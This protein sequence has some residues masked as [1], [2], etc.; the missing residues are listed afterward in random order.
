MLGHWQ[1]PNIDVLLTIFEK[2]EKPDLLKC[3]YTCAAWNTAGNILLYRKVQPSSLNKFQKLIQTISE[4]SPSERNTA[5]A[6]QQLRHLTKD[7]TLTLQC[8]M[9]N[10]S[11]HPMAML[12]RI[13]IEQQKSESDTVWKM[14]RRQ[15]LG[16]LIKNVTLKSLAYNDVAGYLTQLM[17]FV[18]SSPNVQTADIDYLQIYFAL[19]FTP[20]LDWEQHIGSNWRQLKDLTLRTYECYKCPI[21]PLSSMESMLQHLYR[22]DTLDWPDFLYHLPHPVPNMKNLQ[23]LRVDISNK[24]SYEKLKELLQSCR[25]TLR[26]LSIR[27]C[28]TT[29]TDHA[30]LDLEGLIKGLVKLKDFA[31]TYGYEHIFTISSFGD[32]LETLTLI[33]SSVEGEGQVH[34][35][36]GT[37]V[38]KTRNLKRLEIRY[39]KHIGKYMHAILANNRSTL[40]S[41]LIASRNAAEVV[42]SLQSK[43]IRI[44]SVTTLGFHFI[45][46]NVQ[47]LE[48]ARIFPQVEW[49]SLP[50]FSFSGSKRWIDSESMVQ[51][52]HLKG[53]DW[54]TSA[55]LVDPCKFYD[56]KVQMDWWHRF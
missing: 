46:N 7:G 20:K 32:Q 28:M 23:S 18:R 49:L 4:P 43:D 27:W 50:D 19:D 31:L 13:T 48:L 29:T 8:R 30:V 35:I 17:K 34:E 9:V 41:I 39:C 3:S 24:S 11:E 55:Q 36:V 44:A 38:S 26:S 56:M 52:R 53:I 5:I 21:P 22:L 37:A 45:Q 10:I 16:K 51:F 6:I 47:L 42:A 12:S 15:Q 40:Q 54:R 14:K 2:L 33:S 25:N 1:N